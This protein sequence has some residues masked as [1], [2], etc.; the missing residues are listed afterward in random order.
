MAREELEFLNDSFFLNDGDYVNEENEIDPKNQENTPASDVINE[1]YVVGFS[2]IM[3]QRVKRF[4]REGLTFNLLVAGR[5]GCGKT[6]F[7]NSMF[8]TELIDNASQRSNTILEKYRCLV[9]DNSG[10]K[11]RL[12][13][14]ETPGYGSKINN[15]Y[16]WI[17]LIN[18]LEE[19]MSGYVFQEEQ[20]DRRGKISDSRIHCCLY[21]I[22]AYDF[23][24]HP[25]DVMTMRE[26][27][28]RCNLVPVISKCDYL[29]TS[30]LKILRQKVKDV[31]SGQ[32]IQVCK[33]FNSREIAKQYY[34]NAPYD[35]RIQRSQYHWQDA[36][37]KRANTLS[38]QKNNV[39]YKKLRDAII[40]ENLPEF[41]ESTEMHYERYRQFILKFRMKQYENRKAE[42]DEGAALEGETQGIQEYMIYNKIDKRG[43]DRDLMAIANPTYLRAVL[44]LQKRHQCML[45]LEA[46]REEKRLQALQYH[47]DQFAHEIKTLHDQIDSLTGQYD[48]RLESSATLVHM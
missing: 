34:C 38:R 46:Q 12:N 17:P 23:C 36:M 37:D 4:S 30:E 11:L 39:R 29:T 7:I 28:S 18:Y 5:A 13:I 15:E 14:V 10:V 45:V 47:Q 3:E 1:N 35:I 40:G 2:N 32:N 43:M 26:I 44:Q 27:S 20:P 6:T 25:V 48:E 31:M 33:F 24:I 42:V 8:D 22:E 41:V 16:C 19:Q 21:F 9:E